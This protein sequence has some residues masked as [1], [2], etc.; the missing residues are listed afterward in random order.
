MSYFWLLCNGC[1]LYHM[2]KTLLEKG[3]YL[4][5]STTPRRVSDCFSCFHGQLV[6]WRWGFTWARVG[7]L[8]KTLLESNGIWISTGWTHKE[9]MLLPNFFDQTHRNPSQRGQ[10]FGLAILE[11]E[12]WRSSNQVEIKIL[13]CKSTLQIPKIPSKSK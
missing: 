5:S 10:N 6:S 2:W 8:S 7:K 11:A 9:H 12:K 1:R 3:F 4:E 13:L